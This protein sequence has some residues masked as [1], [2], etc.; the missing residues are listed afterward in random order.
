SDMDISLDEPAPER[1]AM[2]APPETQ[3]IE[4]NPVE[5]SN[6]YSGDY[7]ASRNTDHPDTDVGQWARS[8]TTLQQA[9]RT[10]LCSYQLNERD[11]YMVEFVIEAIDEDGYLRVPFS[12]LADPS[13]FT[14]P[15]SEAEW[16]V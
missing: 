13:Q 9:L 2:D 15:A 1:A 8:E 12:E 5:A 7:P 4:P 10:D 3:H 16:E 6:S 11:Q 14:P